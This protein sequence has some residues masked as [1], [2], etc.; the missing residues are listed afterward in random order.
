MVEY[1]A[2]AIATAIKTKKL[3]HDYSIWYG[4]CKVPFFYLVPLD[5]N[6]S[7]QQQQQ[8]PQMKTEPIVAEPSRIIKQKTEQ[9]LFTS[10]RNNW[11][12]IEPR[13]Y[14]E[15]EKYTERRSK[16]DHG[17]R[18]FRQITNQN[19]IRKIDLICFHVD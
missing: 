15:R 11:I 7:E 13:K 14:D 4:I 5:D 18:W 19:W 12:K 8:L 2:V 17:T 10:E 16:D 1:Y 6:K 9:G 3:I